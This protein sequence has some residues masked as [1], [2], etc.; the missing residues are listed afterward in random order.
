MTLR[1]FASLRWGPGPGIAE[2]FADTT[3]PS[4]CHV[5]T[6][7]GRDGLSPG[8]LTLL[9]LRL[10]EVVRVTVIVALGVQ[11]PALLQ[12]VCAMYATNPRLTL[13]GRDDRYPT[14][15]PVNPPAQSTGMMALGK[16]PCK[17]KIGTWRDE[18]T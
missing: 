10:R 16:W 11:D 9:V 12:L 13:T 17:K 6:R 8:L 15:S 14:Q 18:A 4:T 5:R 3:K 7:D 1:C 2:L